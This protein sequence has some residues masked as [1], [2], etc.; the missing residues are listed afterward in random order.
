VIG[1]K[2]FTPV[3]EAVA[4][5]FVLELRPFNRFDTPAIKRSDIDW[6]IGQLFKVLSD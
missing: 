2:L 3:D 1:Y 4:V 5:T 6:A